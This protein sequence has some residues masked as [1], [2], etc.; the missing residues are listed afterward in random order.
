MVVVLQFLAGVWV[1]TS[2]SMGRDV[3]DGGLGKDD[4]ARDVPA[5]KKTVQRESREEES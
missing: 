1:A 3:V 5:R 4:A 2:S